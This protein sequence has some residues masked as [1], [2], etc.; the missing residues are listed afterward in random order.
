MEFIHPV[1]KRPTTMGTF[2][3]MDSDDSNEISQKWLDEPNL[4]L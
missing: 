3:P 1:Y 2:I 4:Q